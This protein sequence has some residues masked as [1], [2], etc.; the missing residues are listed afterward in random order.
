V[1]KVF[2][3]LYPEILDPPMDLGV[4]GIDLGAVR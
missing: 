3:A 4:Y 1:V 2:Y